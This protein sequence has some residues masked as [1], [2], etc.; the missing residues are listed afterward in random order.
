MPDT[1]AHTVLG[2]QAVIAQRLE[3]AVESRLHP[4]PD[5]DSRGATDAFLIGASQHLSAMVRVLV[6]TVRKLLQ[7]GKHEA[8]DLVREC[9]RLEVWLAAAKGKQY[10]QAHAVGRSWEDVWSAVTKQLCAVRE[11]E[12][13]VVTELEERLE[14]AELERLTRRFGEAEIV[15]PTRPH[16]H[17]PHVGRAG[18]LTRQFWVAADSLWDTLEGRSRPEAPHLAAVPDEPLSGRVPLARVS[19][20]TLPEARDQLGAT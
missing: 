2:S 20:S 19:P 15:A 6:P 7:D 9:R 1:L 5:G 4:V 16:P 3:Q 17:S 11:A 12:G 18:W 10:G 8:Q 14:G 13:R